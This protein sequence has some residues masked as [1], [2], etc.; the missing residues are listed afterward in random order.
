[1]PSQDRAANALR[2][3][4]PTGTQLSERSA[5]ADRRDVVVTVAECE[6]RLR[7]LPVGW[8]RQVHVA[9]SRPPRPDVLVAPS[10]SPGARRSAREAGIGWVDESGAAEIA[11]P[12]L[13]V[14]KTGIPQTPL[15][16][17]VGWRPATLAICE[18]LLAGR[19]A[20]TVESAVE[21]TGLSVGTAVTA[22][23]FLEKNGHLTSSAARG[24]DAA[25]RVLDQNELLDAYAAAADRLRLPT[26]VRVGALW[27]EPI[28]GAV[29]AGK[30]W[31][32]ANIAWVATSAMSA[33]VMAPIQT[34]VAPLEIYVSARSPS[35]LHRVAEVAG[36]K[37]IEGGRLLLRPFPTPAADRLSVVLSRGLRSMLWPRV[38]ADLRT[39]GVRG[40]EAAEHLREEM[41]RGW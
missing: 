15:D 10:M 28:V 33:A 1:V 6:L 9:L 24:R 23:K 40:E 13:V 14:S 35:D 17:N 34:E 20:A 41:S 32:R 18:A 36:L 29:D 11:L 5:D 4:L 39:T 19:A 37:P 22:L 16:A 25:R 21:A 38:Y 31:S 3:V 30:R 2:A 27:R 26:A 7:W 12:T 8:P